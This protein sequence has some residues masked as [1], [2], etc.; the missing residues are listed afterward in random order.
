MGRVY[1]LKVCVCVCVSVRHHSNFSTVERGVGHAR[2]SSSFKLVMVEE[3]LL[4]L[5]SKGELGMRSVSMP[6]S[7]FDGGPSSLGP[8]VNLL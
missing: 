4:G 5:S 1:K 2:S 8:Y 7:S 6:I 3:N